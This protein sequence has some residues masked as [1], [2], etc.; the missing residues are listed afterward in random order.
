MDV[1]RKNYYFALF[2]AFL[3]PI[4]QYWF[5]S[6][7]F[8]YAFGLIVLFILSVAFLPEEIRLFVWIGITYLLG[9]FAFIYGER[10]ITLLPLE[11]SDL[12]I[13]SR[14]LL[15][16]PSLFISYITLK[17]GEK[18]FTY[19]PLPVQKMNTI[20]KI[21][22]ILGYGIFLVSFFL[23]NGPAF[24]LL[25]KVI[26]YVVIQCF[27]VELLW[28]GILLRR[29]EVL[30]GEGFAVFFTSLSS[31]LAYML[32]QLSIFYCIFLF[33]L[34]IL[35]GKLTIKFKSIWPACFIHSIVLLCFVQF[36]IIPFIK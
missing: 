14:F 20:W 10:I 36:Q 6:H 27:A 29:M 13:L 5:Q 11:E 30:I 25:F 9:L 15:F 1:V 28:R 34:F 7:L 4:G 35:L 16:I 32:F 26:I 21:I 22:V 3:I 24:P 19:L 8:N 33:F 23:Q 18:I 31:A 12:L 17:F 2:I